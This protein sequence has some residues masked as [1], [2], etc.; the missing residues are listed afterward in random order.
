MDK[1][2]DS[3][4]PNQVCTLFGARPGSSIVPGS[5]YISAGFSLDTAD[6]WRRNFLVLLGWFILFLFTQLVVIEYFQVGLL[7]SFGNES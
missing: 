4:G 1:Y 6:L 7:G 2:P 5:D 3:L